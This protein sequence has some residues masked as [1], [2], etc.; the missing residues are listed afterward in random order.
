MAK[1]NNSNNFPSVEVESV[2]D[3]QEKVKADLNAWAPDAS[4]WISRGNIRPW[5]RGQFDSSK[6]PLPCVLR[7]R[8]YDE[9]NLTTSFRNR[10][11]ALGD[12]TPATD[13]IDQWL[14]LMQHFGAPTRLLD[15][16]ES[17]LLSLFFA[18]R[19]TAEKSYADINEDKVN[20]GVWMINPIELNKITYPT[21]NGF[22]NICV[23]MGS[24]LPLT[25]DDLKKII[26]GWGI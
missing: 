25:L 24:G 12:K 4:D 3:F 17:P 5:F 15:W 19:K 1:D 16:T 6:K 2:T 11:L 18:V 26:P 14:F 13:R 8:G 9:F 23:R 10:A 22:P 20:P 21:F 7:D